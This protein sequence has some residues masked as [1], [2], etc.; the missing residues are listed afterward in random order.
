MNLLQELTFLYGNATKEGYELSQEGRSTVNQA[1]YEAQYTAA[2]NGYAN[3]DS[4]LAATFGKGMTYD[5][6]K[7]MLRSISFLRSMRRTR[8]RPSPSLRRIS[9]LTM[10]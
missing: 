7:E 6:Y 3:V 8:R 4:Y 2:T 10:I 5:Y 1:L 9:Q